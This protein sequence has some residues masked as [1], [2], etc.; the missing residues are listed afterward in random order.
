MS[1]KN[2]I[3]G[4]IVFCIG[5]GSKLIQ[6]QL[7]GSK[8]LLSIP[9]Y[10]L[11]YFYPHW[12]EW[13]KKYSK[14]DSKLALKLISKHHASIFDSRLILGNNGLINL[15]KKKNQYIKTS[16]KN[17]DKF[18]IHYLKSRKISSRNVL[19]A[20]HF[21]YFKSKKTKLTKMKSI[22]YHIHE[23]DYFNKYLLRDF[24]DSQLIVCCRDP[25]NY[26]WKKIRLDHFIEKERFD[27]TERIYFKQFDYLNSLDSIFTGFKNIPSKFF[28]NYHIVK[29]EDLKKKNL[30]VIKKLEKYLNIKIPKNTLKP[31][32]DGL[33][34]WSD[35]SYEKNQKVTFDGVLYDYRKDLI[36]FF[37]YEIFIL[38]YILR[39][40][41]IKAN[42]K[43]L[44]VKSSLIKEIFFFITILL[45]TKNGINNLVFFLNPLNLYLF[46]KSTFVESFTKNKLKNYY[47]NAMYKHKKQY[48]SKTFI[49]YNYFRKYIYKNEN[50]KNLI[51]FILVNRIFN[52]LFKIFFYLAIPV[53][54]L[55]LYF[56]RIY[57]LIFYYF[58]IKTIN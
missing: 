53:N 48:A 27:K 3:V 19:L 10:P 56:K 46:I 34:W 25:I 17:F 44:I 13:Q 58:K 5:G 16:K 50:K 9:A 7:D 14:I 15:G 33:S 41:F 47:F 21:A 2:R 35:K 29:F 22:L 51:F 38:K 30:N 37:K 54:L 42:Y 20:V 40:F 57:L 23:A 36:F 1:F 43:N 8:E 12:R 49:K 18:F 31:T 24:K 11:K 52:F 32:F 28:V 26:F 6:S 45:P 4:L 55:F 39:N